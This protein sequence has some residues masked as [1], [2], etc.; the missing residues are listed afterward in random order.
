MLRTAARLIAAT[1]I[2]LTLV[3]GAQPAHAAGP[4]VEAGTNGLLC[5]ILKISCP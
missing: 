2:S 3:L 1:T 5:K 4:V